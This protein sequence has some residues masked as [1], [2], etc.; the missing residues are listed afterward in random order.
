[1]PPATVVKTSVKKLKS[2]RYE[3][4]SERERERER[5]GEKGVYIR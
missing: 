5:E 4:V 2:S 1:M 3:R